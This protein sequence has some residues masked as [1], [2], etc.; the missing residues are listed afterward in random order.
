[1]RRIRAFFFRVAGLFDRRR[2]RELAD[3][4]ESHLQLHIEDNLRC[5]M[6][7]VE[8]RRQ[9]LIKLGG[10]E[11]TKEIYRDRRG[12]PLVESLIQD[13]RYG[14]RMMAKNPA[15]TAVVVGTLA[16]GIGG[17]TAIFSLIYGGLL[18]PFPYA[19]SQ[20]LVA[21]TSRDTR[22]GSDEWYARISSPEVLDY[23]KESQVFDEVLASAGTDVLLTGIDS[24][25]FF[26]GASVT[27]NTFRVLGV[28][29]LIGRP[30]M[31]E[32]CKAG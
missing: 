12:F 6:T 3:E 5:G 26:L 24:P 17:T 30:I 21:L 4:L 13:V 22:V 29:P 32:D 1:M 23:R 20:R 18:N 14:L 9:A 25:Q 28:P 8:A 15:F 31:P 2:E 11:Q 16:L 10:V 7:P 19:D 27:E